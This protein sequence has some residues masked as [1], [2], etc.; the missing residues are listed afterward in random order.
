M[1][2]GEVTFAEVKA[3]DGPR[4]YGSCKP[5]LEL[6][7][8]QLWHRQAAYLFATGHYSVREVATAMDKSES[9]V[10]NLLR[11]GWF[12]D[13]VTTLMAK[14]G[15]KDIMAMFKAEQVNCLATLIEMRDNIKTPPAVRKAICTDIL[16]RTLGK[17]VQ[18]LETTQV[19]YSDDPVAEAERLEQENARLR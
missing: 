1:D 5:T 10:H 2:D 18:R 4:L 11:N 7:Y 13:L 8:E 6:Q 17:A 12:Q 9:T 15:G 14:H 19:P 16:D 3:Q